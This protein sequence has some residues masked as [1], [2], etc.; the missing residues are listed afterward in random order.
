[1]HD[2][3][4]TAIHEIG[5]ALAAWYNGTPISLLAVGEGIQP[6][7][8]LDTDVLGVNRVDGHLLLRT[9][10]ETGGQVWLRDPK[11]PASARGEALM[12]SLL[13]ALAGPAAQW[14]SLGKIDDDGNDTT[15]DELLVDGGIGPGCGGDLEQVETI[16]DLMPEEH[17]PAA[18]TLAC[19]RA[20]ALVTRYWSEIQAMAE[21]LL[22]QRRLEQHGIDLMMARYLDRPSWAG[23]L[24]MGDLDPPTTT[25]G[26]AAVVPR[27]ARPA[28]WRW[29]LQL[30]VGGYAL[31]MP[32]SLLYLAAEEG[33][34]EGLPAGWYALT[35]YDHLTREPSPEGGTLQAFAAEVMATKLAEL[36][37]SPSPSVDA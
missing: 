28:P 10:F 22:A 14:L 2:Q 8:D 12:R 32:R 20:E 31:S 36:R 23:A 13:E 27:W 24:H 34:E 35:D 21:E 5:H 1:M 30:Y 25:L 6:Y 17:R 19:W 16:L 7:D 33:A 9:T 15:F 37:R 4:T 26:D 29:N 11:A 18:F 3:T